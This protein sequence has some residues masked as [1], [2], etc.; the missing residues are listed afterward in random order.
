LTRLTARNYRKAAKRE[1]TAI[2]N[3]FISQTGYERKYAIHS[4]MA[5]MNKAIDKL[6][7]LADHVPG[8]V[9]KRALKPLLFG[10][11]GLILT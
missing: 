4:E 5:I 8:F 10:Y 11:Y 3:T 7:A 6:P 9:T 1:K 2:L